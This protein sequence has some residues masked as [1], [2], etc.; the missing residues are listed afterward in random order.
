VW[1][2]R[3]L[4]LILTTLWNAVHCLEFKILCITPTFPFNTGAPQLVVVVGER[5][6]AQSNSPCNSITRSAS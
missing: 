3:L 4:E 2:A 5:F 1:S 6:G